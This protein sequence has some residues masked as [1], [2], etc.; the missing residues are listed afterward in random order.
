MVEDDDGENNSGQISI[1][2]DVDEIDIQPL[3]HNHAIFTGIVMVLQR[4]APFCAGKISRYYP[5]GGRCG[6]RC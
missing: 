1:D 3:M 2:D 4:I 5:Y 6:R